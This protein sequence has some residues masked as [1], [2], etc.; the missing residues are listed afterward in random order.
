MSQF[1]LNQRMMSLPA[2]LWFIFQLTVNA[3]EFTMLDQRTE[4]D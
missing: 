3:N 1:F 2:S 4:A